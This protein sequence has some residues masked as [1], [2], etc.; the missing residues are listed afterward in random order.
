MDQS[1]GLRPPREKAL[2]GARTTQPGR[3]PGQGRARA[4]HQ[5]L[6]LYWR[7]Q[8]LAEE[9]SEFRL[10]DRRLRRLYRRSILVFAELGQGNLRSGDARRIAGRLLQDLGGDNLR[11]TVESAL[12]LSGEAYSTVSAFRASRRAWW[13]TLLGTV[14]AILVA[15]P[16]LQTA[17]DAVRSWKLAKPWDWLLDPARTLAQ[18]SPWA[19]VVTAVAALAAL[20]ILVRVV[21]FGSAFFTILFRRRGYAWPKPSTISRIRAT[22]DPWDDGDSPSDVDVQVET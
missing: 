6:Y 18:L 13:L 17:L 20:W 12:G 16:Q 9:V 7:L 22:E 4:A 15:F 8:M 21:R 14:L 10:G 19:I 5:S 11:Q 1:A 2:K 3:L